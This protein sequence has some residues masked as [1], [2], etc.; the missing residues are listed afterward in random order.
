MNSRVNQSILNTLLRSAVLC[1]WGKLVVRVSPNLIS[2][3]QFIALLLLPAIL[4]VLAV[5]Y[6]VVVLLQ[7]RP[8]IYASE[9]MNAVDKSFRLYKIRTMHPPDPFADERVL[10]AKQARRVT[11]I[12][13]F[14]RCTRLDELPQIFNVLKGEIGFVG[15]RPPL[16]RYVE[17]YP[18]IYS[19]VLRDTLPGITGLATIMVHQR[20][21]RLLAKCFTA[22]HADHV[23]RTRCIPIKA[24]IDLIYRRHNGLR[25]NTF[26]V[27]MTLARLFTSILRDVRRAGGRSLP[28]VETGVGPQQ[29]LRLAR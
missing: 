24:R 9:R 14:L 17:A 10:C 13:R 21:E 1:A 29:E 15:P 11:G 7:G 20:E 8:F 25:L 23:Y 19:E 3:S 27:W 16:R 22:E 6:V 5:L 28:L 18:E 2:M 12:G 26:I 4:C